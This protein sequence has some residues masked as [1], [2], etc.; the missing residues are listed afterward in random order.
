VKTIAFI[1]QKGGTGKSTLA[2]HMGVAAYQ[3]G[4]K[5]AIV[6]TDPQESAAMW[7]RARHASDP[8]VATVAVGDL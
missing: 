7:Q 1:S 6:D 8:P 2:V 4:R 5:T 3:A